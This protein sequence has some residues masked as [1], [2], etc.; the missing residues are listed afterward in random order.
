MTF[1]IGDS[2]ILKLDSQP[3]RGIVAAYNR[4]GR[5]FVRWFDKGRTMTLENETDLLPLDETW[6]VP[7]PMATKGEK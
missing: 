1:S 3:R 4:K 7:A 5:I 6:S 2:V